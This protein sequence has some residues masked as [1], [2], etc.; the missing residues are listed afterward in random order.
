MNRLP[1]S[2]SVPVAFV[3][4]L[5][6]AGAA[7]AYLLVLPAAICFLQGFNHGAFDV[8]VQ[9]RDLYRFGLVTML[10]IG[11]IFQLPVALLALGRAGVIDA[12]ALPG[13]DPVTTLLETLPLIALYEL[14]ILLLRLARLR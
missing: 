14:S 2:T 6:A 12:A 11:A 7:F 9:A 5:F 8:L 13:T 3:P 10:A 4:V 1:F